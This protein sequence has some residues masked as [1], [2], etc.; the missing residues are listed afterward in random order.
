MKPTHLITLYAFT[1]LLL[2][3]GVLF[4]L[5]RAEANT[6]RESTGEP[7]AQICSN[8]MGKYYYDKLK[9]ECRV[10]PAGVCMQ[11]GQVYETKAACESMCTEHRFILPWLR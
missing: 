10:I 11:N 9:E 3:A 6:C 5:S 4:W 2:M 8:L 1:I 7:A